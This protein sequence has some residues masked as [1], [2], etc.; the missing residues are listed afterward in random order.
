M[1]FVDPITYVRGAGTSEHKRAGWE[2]LVA[3]WG[4]GRRAT[5]LYKE[6]FWELAWL[7]SQ[8]LVPRNSSR[9]KQTAVPACVVLSRNESALEKSLR[10]EAIARETLSNSNGSASLAGRTFA[11]DCVRISCGESNARWVALFV[12]AARE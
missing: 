10:T 9:C 6:L 4:L 7:I 2:T 1:L 3:K 11:I 12:V 8:D 5:L